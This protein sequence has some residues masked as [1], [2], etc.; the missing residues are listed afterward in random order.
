AGVF[1]IL[2]SFCP[3]TGPSN[4]QGFSIFPNGTSTDML[5]TIDRISR[6]NPF[7][8][9]NFSMFDIDSLPDMYETLI[10][11]PTFVYDSLSNLTYS[12]T[13]NLTIICSFFVIQLNYTNEE[14]EHLLNHT[15]IAV[16]Q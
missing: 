11:R 5:M 15:A 7:F 2:Q 9:Q 8:T 6:T 12:F 13:K 4:E 16:N 14:C 3:K 10:D 1:S